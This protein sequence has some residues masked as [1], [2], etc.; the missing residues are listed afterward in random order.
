MRDRDLALARQRAA[1]SVIRRFF[2]GRKR[3]IRAAGLKPDE[4]R[5]ALNAGHTLV[6]ETGSMIK[7]A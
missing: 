2:A 5:A 4:F 7:K 1:A 6:S 3:T